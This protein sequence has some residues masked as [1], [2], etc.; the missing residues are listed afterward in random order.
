MPKFK[1]TATT[2]DGATVTGLENAF[3]V[4]MARRALLAKDLSPVDVREKKAS[5]PSRSPRRRSSVGNSC[6][7]LDR[8]RSS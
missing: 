4:G 8:W 6:I 3:T 2:P 7:S 1:F 5:S